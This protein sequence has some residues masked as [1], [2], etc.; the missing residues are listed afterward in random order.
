MSRSS[1]ELKRERDRYYDAEIYSGKTD[2]ETWQLDFAGDAVFTV[3]FWDREAGK[4]EEES[5]K[6]RMWQTI[7]LSD[8][9]LL[10]GWREVVDDKLYNAITYRL[11]SD[12]MIEYDK[13]EGEG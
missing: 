5:Y 11:L 10:I 1:Q 13:T 6:H 12:C 8:G 4:W 9:E 2:L 3:R 7:E